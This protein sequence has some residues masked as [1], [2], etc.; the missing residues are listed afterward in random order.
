MNSND[1]KED[2]EQEKQAERKFA[3]KIKANQISEKYRLL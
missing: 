2:T 1:I 3:T